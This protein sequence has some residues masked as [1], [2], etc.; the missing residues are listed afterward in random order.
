MTIKIIIPLY[1]DRRNIKNSFPAGSARFYF[2][3]MLGRQNVGSNPNS[4]IYM[5]HNIIQHYLLTCDTEGAFGVTRQL[6]D[7]NANLVLDKL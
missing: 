3:F 7:S 4:V 5:L 1:G 2:V 6:L